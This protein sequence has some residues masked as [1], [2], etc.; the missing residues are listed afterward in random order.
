MS[1]AYMQVMIWNTGNGQCLRTVRHHTGAA[2][3]CAWFSDGLHFLTA[4]LDRSSP[5]W[6]HCG[7]RNQASWQATPWC[8]AWIE[9]SLKNVCKACWKTSFGPTW[10]LWGHWADRSQL[11]SCE[12][13]VHCSAGRSSCATWLDMRC[14]SG[15]WRRVWMTS[16]SLLTH[17]SS[18]ASQPTKAS[19]SCGSTT[20]F[21]SDHNRL[22]SHDSQICAGHIMASNS[23]Q[24]NYWWCL[25]KMRL[26]ILHSS[27]SINSEKIH[28][29]WGST[30]WHEQQTCA[31][32]TIPNHL[33]N[34]SSAGRNPSSVV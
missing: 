26:K 2:A 33:E 23:V 30:R 5:S 11:S 31:V 8:H 12:C 19:S 22:P 14:G 9:E 6:C 29:D 18:C 3:A 34:N 15:L 32:C 13:P 1:L 25:L 27:V 24:V 7:R 16:S 4:G 20:L 28:S 10:Q 21:R 17:R